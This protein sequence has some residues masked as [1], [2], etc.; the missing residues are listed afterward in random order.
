MLLYFIKCHT[1]LE[2]FATSP[3]IVCITGEPSE[4]SRNAPRKNGRIDK[5]VYYAPSK[6]TRNLERN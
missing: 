3:A 4:F 2:K 5:C 6:I 1:P